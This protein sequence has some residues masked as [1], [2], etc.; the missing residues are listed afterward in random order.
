MARKRD[1]AHDD[2]DVAAAHPIR[3]VLGVL[4]VL[5]L[6]FVL[7]AQ[8][9]RPAPHENS[10]DVLARYHAN[11]VAHAL[12][13]MDAAPGALRGSGAVFG[14]A[15]LRHYAARL[16]APTPPAFAMGPLRIGMTYGDFQDLAGAALQ[17]HASK[18]GPMAV[19]RRGENVFTAYFPNTQDDAPATRLTYIRR[20]QGQSEKQITAY[21]GDLWGKPA[22]TSC[23]R[24]IFDNG[25]DCR[26]DWWPINGVKVAV[27]MRRTQDAP[28]DPAIIVLRIDAT[29]GNTGKPKRR[30]FLL[31]A[32]SR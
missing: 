2:L 18:D 25:Q 8:A 11:H 15:S 21:L 24:L 1:N 29:D 14:G 9:A 23:R 32:F 5:S 30:N 27:Q 3:T 12:P 7:L 10:A 13:A 22:N 16:K 31:A 6:V 28:H 20:F 19:L 17:V 4:G 26:F